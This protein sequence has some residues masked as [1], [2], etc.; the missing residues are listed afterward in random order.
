MPAMKNDK[1][2]SKLL[3]LYTENDTGFS[4]LR[5]DRSPVPAPVSCGGGEGMKHKSPL[6]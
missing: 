3:Q 1:R 6:L 5:A 2:V 4:S